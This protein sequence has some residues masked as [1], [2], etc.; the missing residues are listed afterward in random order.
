MRAIARDPGRYS[1]STDS[2]LYELV[3]MG[4]IQ[5]IAN[6]GFEI[7]LAGRAALSASTAEGVE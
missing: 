1:K 5:R 2:V 6:G 4:L 7:T 3:E